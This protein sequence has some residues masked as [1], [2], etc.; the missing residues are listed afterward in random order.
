VE[1]G[2]IDRV[3]KGLVDGDDAGRKRPPGEELDITGQGPEGAAAE[4]PQE[5]PLGLERA[6]QPL[7]SLLCILNVEDIRVSVFPEVDVIRFIPSGDQIF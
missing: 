7:K 5:P 6:L 2:E 4:I 1:V 3:A